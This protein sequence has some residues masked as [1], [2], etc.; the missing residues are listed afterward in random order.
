LTLVEGL[1][2]NA[3]TTL[4]ESGAALLRKYGAEPSPPNLN[5]AIGSSILNGALN[6]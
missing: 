3:T 2:F 5:R 6:R 4:S 1:Y